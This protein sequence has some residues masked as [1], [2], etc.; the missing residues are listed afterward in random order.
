MV[1]K[2]VNANARD[3]S[4][5]SV[6]IPKHMI[7]YA[8][9]LRIS[10]ASW[11]GS[12]IWMAISMCFHLTC[13]FS[14]SDAAWYSSASTLLVFFSSLM[15]CIP[16]SRGSHCWV[17]A[18]PLPAISCSSEGFT[19][20]SVTAVIKAP[21][22]FW[23]RWKLIWEKKKSKEYNFVEEW[24]VGCTQSLSARCGLFH[25]NNNAILYSGHMWLAHLQRKQCHA[26]NRRIVSVIAIYII[27]TRSSWADLWKWEA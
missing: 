27:Q 23:K 3:L 10:L 20:L 11:Y 8:R 7:L 17:S 22:F 19:L 25:S 16:P 13:L 24:T 14:L 1:E 6:L 9:D 4:R 18:K 5:L 26:S 15:S 21:A 12:G 2:L